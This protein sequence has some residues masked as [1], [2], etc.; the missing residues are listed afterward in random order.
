M[1]KTLFA[2]IA[3][4]CFTVVASAQCPPGGC[5]GNV[6]SVKDSSPIPAGAYNIKFGEAKIIS[7]GPAQV[8]GNGSCCAPG[9]SCCYPG[10][11]CCE[12]VV[13]CPQRVAAPAPTFVNWAP[14]TYYYQSGG[15]PNGT[16]PSQR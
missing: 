6:V 7:V 8:V 1:K 16:C 9:A 11:P 5:S 14:R 4:L 12:G 10:S 2:V 13:A 3:L 15:C